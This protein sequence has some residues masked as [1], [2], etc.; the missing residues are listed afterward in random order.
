[1]EAPINNQVAI[2]YDYD[3]LASFR[4]QRQS[5]LLDSSVEMQRFYKSF[6]DQNVGVD[7]I[8]EDRDFSD[9]KV[10]ILPQMIITKPEMEKCIHEFVKNGGTVVVTYRH[11][12][13]DVDNNIPFGETMPVHYG[14]LTGLTIEETESLQDYEAFPVIGTGEFEGISGKGGIFRDMI[15]VKDAEVL[16]YYGDQFYEEFA[17]ITRKKTEKGTIYYVGCG[18]EEKIT[19]LL[20]EHIMKE[21]EIKMT[22]S[23]EGVEIVTRGNETQKVVMYINHNTH[24]VKQGEIT[25][26]PFECKIVSL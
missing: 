7:V 17:A 19:N 6:H 10:V 8:P 16:F 4:I 15:Q 11:A 2:V 14:D 26:A 3:S 23:E 5:I 20:M 13:K 1:M 24:E 18:L 25:L 12:V 21:C 9:Y 22:P